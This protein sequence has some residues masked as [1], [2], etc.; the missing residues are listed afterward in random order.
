[1]RRRRARRYSSS[2]NRM[3]VFD[4]LTAILCAAPLLAAVLAQ[5]PAPPLAGG[6]AVDAKLALER[7]QAEFKENHDPPARDAALR[8]LALYQQLNDPHGIGSASYLLGLVAGRL[9]DQQ[10]SKTQ[11]ERA[12]AAFDAAGDLTGRSRSL[13]G[14]L[15]TSRPPLS[16]ATPLFERAARDARMGGSQD[17]E[18]RIFHSWGD[19]LYAAGEYEAALDKLEQAIPLLEAAGENVAL[20]TV[21][22]SLGR[23]YRVHGRLDAALAQQLKALAIHEKS[24]SLVNPLPSLNAVAVTYQGLGDYP[25]ARSYLERALA[26]ANDSD[27]VG[28]RVLDF[29]SGNLASV[30]YDQ[31][32]YKR[33]AELLEQVVGGQDTYPVVRFRALSYAYLKLGR[34][35]EALVMAQKALD[36]CTRTDIDCAIARDA[37][38]WAYASLGRYEEAIADSRTALDELEDVRARL[39]PNDALKQQ[40]GSTRE[41]IYS[42]AV[43]LQVKQKRGRDALETAELARSRAF[44]DLLAARDLPVKEP[45]S[46][47]PLVLRGLAS[48]ASAPT[49]TVD[50]LAAEAARLRSTM[51]AYWVGEDGVSTW[52][53]NANGAVTSAQVDIQRSKLAELIQR[54]APFSEA[55]PQTRRA[56]ARLG[57]RGSGEIAL[58]EVQPAI[59]RELYDVLIRPIRSALPTIPGALLTI[60]PH[61]PLAALSFAALQNERGR[62]L[63]EDYA[64]HY[65][66]AGSV[67]QFTAGRIKPGAR[68]GAVML[69]ADPSVSQSRLDEPLSAL[70]GSRAEVRAVSRLIPAGRVTL[71]EGARASES[72]IRDV[73]PGKTV[74]HFATHAIVKDD[75]PFGS[76]LALARTTTGDVSDGHLTAQEIYGLRIDADLVILS[77]C[78]SGSGRVTGDGIATLAR[79]FI[80]AGAPSLVTSLWDVADEPTNRLLP[81]FYRSWLAGASKA[82]AL[83]AA[84]LHVLRDLRAGRIQVTTPLG[85]VTLPEHP[86]FWAGFALIGEPK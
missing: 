33:A 63:L 6:T 53:V 15:Q 16:E 73:A 54:T 60:V 64:L 57:T 44:V 82:E 25:R 69:V 51:V 1:M 4:R 52:V 61:G 13:L 71:L 19:R 11:Y 32:E 34:R 30:L 86:V 80:S 56:V 40:F 27:S 35:D 85:P 72:K 77:A 5:S 65:I 38:A 42:H 21:Y 24:D 20:G 26:I 39:A 46:E 8:A 76:Y 37:R 70:P 81:D 31:G 47:A 78:R 18:G 50:D 10:E 58:Q 12:I 43:A 22:N 68:R 9:G 7:G 3:R 23:L 59:W 29:L 66:P 49:A 36:R 83:R 45:A 17:V 2:G 48:G 62:Y 75:D 74:L 79:A 67:L 14:L 84:Q 28:A 41:S 55:Q